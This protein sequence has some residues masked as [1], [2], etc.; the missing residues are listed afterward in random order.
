PPVARRD[1][2]STGIRRPSGPP[3]RAGP[4]PDTLGRPG[5]HGLAAR[6]H[7]ETGNH[8][9]GVE[10][11]ACHRRRAVPR[12]HHHRPLLACARRGHAPS[13]ADPRSVTHG[14]A[15]SRGSARGSTTPP[16]ATIA[17]SGV[18]M[19]LDAHLPIL[20]TR[21]IAIALSL[22]IASGIL[23]ATRVTPIQKQ[24]RTLA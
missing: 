1:R 18:L 24:L 20:R 6:P 11:A 10:A 2:S 23:F 7:P 17:V 14:R 16:A 21:W 12:Q 9:P 4:G 3:S 19:A 15:A 13:P 22:F 5:G 8:V